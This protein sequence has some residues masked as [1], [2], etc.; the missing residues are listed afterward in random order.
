MM[1]PA[2]FSRTER[3]RQQSLAAKRIDPACSRELQGE[4][5][6]ALASAISKRRF[7]FHSGDT[8]EHIFRVAIPEV[9]AI[10]EREGFVLSFD[11][12]EMTPQALARGIVAYSIKRRAVN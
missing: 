4:I 10:A 8:V 1:R 12:P 2:T 7:E 9:Y 3:R 11:L 6:A 5:V